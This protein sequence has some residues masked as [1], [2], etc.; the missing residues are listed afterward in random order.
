M[1]IHK[2][3]CRHTKDAD[4]ERLVEVSW[5]PSGDEVYAAKLRVTSQ[6]GKGILA[7]ISS[8]MALKDANIIQADIKTTAD[9]R[10]ISNFTIE[11]TNAQQLQDII[12]AIKKIKNV[13]LVERM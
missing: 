4:P 5:E 12:T 13:S 9:R 7:Q 1:T 2:Y 6:G 11:V 10:G 8:T 3:N